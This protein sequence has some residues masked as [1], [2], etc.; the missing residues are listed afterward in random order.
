MV[1]CVV[2]FKD[3]TKKIC[4]TSEE[5]I[6]TA[7]V[8]L[9]PHLLKDCQYVVQYFDTDVNQYI[10]VHEGIGVETIKTLRIKLLKSKVKSEWS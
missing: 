6:S 7:V 3:E 1:Y 2:Q 5:D 10:D 8:D 4:I 9:W